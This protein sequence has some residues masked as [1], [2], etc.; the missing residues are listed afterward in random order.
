MDSEAGGNFT[1]YE[2]MF[3]FDASDPVYEAHFPEY[4]VVPGSLIIH[5][6]LQALQEKGI[7][8]KNLRIENFSF[9]E[10]LPPGAC[11]FRMAG[12]SGKLECR[13]TKDGKKIAAGTL[14]YET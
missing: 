14:I 9:R 6:F 5:A 4:P 8:V 3:N 2:G 13:I 12:R 11:R 7:A 1:E 10:F